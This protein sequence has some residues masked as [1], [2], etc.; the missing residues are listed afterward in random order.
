MRRQGK[1]KEK[2]IDIKGEQKGKIRKEK[3]KKR[4][5][6]RKEKRMIMMESDTCEEDGK[7]E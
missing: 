5:E 2:S 1:E 4:G 6:E 7:I 3:G